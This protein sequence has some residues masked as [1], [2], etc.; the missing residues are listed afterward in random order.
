[1]IRG[2]L[3][4]CS[5]L[6][7]FYLPGRYYESEADYNNQKIAYRTL[8]CAEASCAD[9]YAICDN[10]Q[11]NLKCPASY[12][13][14]VASFTVVTFCSTLAD[15]TPQGAA[16]NCLVPPASTRNALAVGQALPICCTCLPGD[17][18]DPSTNSICKTKFSAEPSQC[19]PI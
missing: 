1:M 3:A 6:F 17:C 5:D 18:Q 4:Q 13:V 11:G 2:S 19:G 12:P 15:S 8:S 14:G 16:R 9:A 7:F 10:A